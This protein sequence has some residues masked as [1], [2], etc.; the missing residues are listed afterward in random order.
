MPRSRSHMSPRLTRDASRLVSLA[1]SLNSSGSRVEDLFWEEQLRA[2]IPKLLRAGNDA[3]LEAALD[4]LSQAQ[5]GAYEVLIEQAE[6]FTESTI[7]EKNGASYD[8]L[9]IVA[10][11]VAWTRYTIPTGPILPAA[12]QTLTAQL[13]G[14]ILAQGARLA[15]MPHL[16]SIDQMPRTFSETWHWLQR[17]G[18]QALGAE[19]VKPAISEDAETANMLA[20]TRYLVG[21]VAVPRGTPIFR[22]QESPGD[23]G[24]TREACLAQWVAQ[25]QPT[26]AALL[27]GCGFECLLP[28]AYYV[29]N[30]EAD[31]RV[32]P[33]AVRA[34]VTWLEGAVNLEPARLRAVVAGCGEGRIDEYRVA[35]TARNSNDVIYG[36]VWPLYGREDDS[37]SDD[38]RPDPVEEIA[39]LLKE[40]GVNEVRR[41]PG[42]LPAEYCED[43]GTPYFPNP[44]GEM[45]HAELPEDAESAPA[46]F[47]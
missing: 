28:D 24:A 26:L 29:S 12:L 21:A 9:L 6:T 5:A 2:T 43:C 1:L 39:A 40:L 27:P 46:K 36:C 32:R 19:T 45:V 37:G 35:F 41:I 20:D 25:A 23:A 18:S 31:R 11:M 16:V 10:P 7:I 14:H 42:V 4:H 38:E 13:H 47:H 8:V 15:L 22:W 17:L 33:L 30:R 3:P 44:L 34:A